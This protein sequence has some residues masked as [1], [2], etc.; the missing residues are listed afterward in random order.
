M[1]KMLLLWLWL[2]DCSVQTICKTWLQFIQYVM[3]G[4][5][6]YALV[7]QRFLGFPDIGLGKLSANKAA[8]VMR[9]NMSEVCG[10]GVLLDR[11]PGAVSC[12]AAASGLLASTLHGSEDV[13]R[14]NPPDANPLLYSCK[15][16]Y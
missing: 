7:P 2:G 1:G 9:L 8:E 16:L 5:G 11:L 13:G 12:H 10:L 4:S 14:Y 15:S 6:I 3:P